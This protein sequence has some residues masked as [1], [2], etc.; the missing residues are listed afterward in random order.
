M[1]REGGVKGERAVG[2][3]LQDLIVVEAGLGETAEW[4]R[5]GRRR[6]LGWRPWAHV[7]S[8]RLAADTTEKGGPLPQ[9]IGRGVTG[10]ERRGWMMAGGGEGERGRRTS[11]AHIGSRHAYSLTS[12]LTFLAGP[13][14]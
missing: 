4:L 7:P 10:G 9:G 1:G 11:C 8:L 2:H 13:S 3:L 5:L 6:W 12:P 14:H